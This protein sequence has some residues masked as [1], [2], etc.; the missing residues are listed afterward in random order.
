MDLL[1]RLGGDGKKSENVSKKWRI[2]QLDVEVTVRLLHSV[3]LTS[4]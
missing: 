1:D 4:D 2:T 3:P